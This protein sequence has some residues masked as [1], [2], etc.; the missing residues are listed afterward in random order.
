MLIFFRRLSCILVFMMVMTIAHAE[1]AAAD[2]SVMLEHLQSMKANFTQTAYN[3]RGKTQ[4]VAY[5]RMALLRPG[6][7]RWEV[8]KPMPQLIIANQTNSLY[9]HTRPQQ[10]RQVQNF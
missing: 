4:Q 3:A 6:R 5:G 2:L 8:L 9:I 10:G 7:F 1:T